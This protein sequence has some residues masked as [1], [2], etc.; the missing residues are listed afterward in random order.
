M[1][2][3]PQRWDAP[4]GPEMADAEV[5]RLLALPEFAS[6]AADRFPKHT[7]LDG[8]LRN[9]TRIVRYRGGDIV[10]RESDYGN[11]AFLVVSGNLRVVITPALPRNLIGRQLSERKNFFQ[12]L[13]QL[14][15]NRT[16]PEVRDTSRYGG[17]SVREGGSHEEADARVFLQD[18]PAV[19]N[20]HN[21]AQLGP[22]TLFGELAALG[23]VPRTATIFAE[24]EAE[25]LEIRWQG[26]RELRKYDPGWR[27]TIDERYRENA[28]KVRLKSS[29]YFA[30]LSE[31][32]LGEVADATL[33]ESHGSFEWHVAY[34][35]MRDQG[36]A[37]KEPII[38]RQGEYPD[39][40][41]M[42]RAGFARVSIKMG[43]G[44]RT[45]TYLGAG[46]SFGHDELWASH[47]GTDISLQT[48]L[49]AVGY[50][51]LLRVPA[52]ILEKY[53][54][55]KE[56][57]HH[58]SNPLHHL[59]TRTV[60]QDA[61]LEW[62]V[63]Q[64][65]VN[66]TKAMLIDLDRC[67]RCDDCVRAC[68]STHGGNPRFIRHGRT[69]DHWMVANACMHCADPV[70]MIGCPTGAV[71]R[72]LETGAV[73]INDDTCIG[74]GVCASSCPYNNIRLV[75]IHDI[76]GNM[77]RDPVNQKPIVKATKC[78]LCETN[79]GGPACVRAC[80]H[81]ALKRVN[82]QGDETFG[83]AAP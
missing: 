39:G 63:E 1:I 58:I 11:S 52:P 55:N 20:S 76:D 5:A 32:E 78:D 7:P 40:L 9:D 26:L 65:F 28:L 16:V 44:E 56:G 42:I 18:I 4:F 43:N 73:V 79:P 30:G 24:E 22:S 54:F 19:L 64:R 59:A 2:A 47:L 67:V 3:R 12:A 80:P 60:A 49:K 13:A 81:D 8:I 62:A 53:V 15:T 23:R 77:V 70:C 17:Q 41:L 72:S 45:L 50:V 82:F 61:P 51:D 75:D 29:P 46:D 34:K 57:G 69:F 27:R 38:A 25:L 21:T 68:A 83:G 6:I 10:V 48:S 36:K 74:C 71:H 33:F 31:Q 37:D 66:G 35:R 14:W